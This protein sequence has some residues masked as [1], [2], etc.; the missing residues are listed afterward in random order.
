MKKSILFILPFVV[1]II[2][3]QSCG[4]TPLPCFTTDVD[5]DSIHVYQPVTFLTVCTRDG[6]DFSWEF[7]DNDD[8]IEFGR[9]VVKSFPDTGNV[10]VYLQ[11]TN[12]NK[13]AS[14][15]KIIR[16]LP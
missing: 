6:K 15:S 8:S 13:I 14:T 4:K 11:V 3:I 2:A 12:G 10:K 16:V 9:V 5:I 1:F 7:Y